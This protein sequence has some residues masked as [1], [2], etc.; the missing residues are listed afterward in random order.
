MSMKRERWE[1]VAQMH[2]AALE[3][4]EAAR[5]TFLQK[6][7]A[8]D[9][10]LRREVESLLA[11]EADAENF[12]DGS[13]LQAVAKKLAEEQRPHRAL[14]PG[15]KLGSYVIVGELG[16]GGMGEVYRARDSSLKREVAIKVLPA[17]Y[18]RDPDR[19]R[20]FELEAQAA[21]TLNH[22]NILSILHIG[23]QGGSPYIVSELLEGETLGDRLSQGPMRR[24]EAV[25]VAVAVA[26][27]LAAAH[28]KGITHRDLK[29]QNL[30]LGRDGRVKILDFG[31]AKLTQ[32]QA[33]SASGSMLT[34]GTET[35]PGI[36]LGTVGYMSPE[37]VRGQPADARSDIFAL[38]AVL[39]EM[40]TGTRAFHKPTSAETMYAILN[41]DPPNV[42]HISPNIPPALQRVMQRCLE[43]NPELRFQSS[44]DLAFAL[45]ALSDSGS[46][47]TSVI[48]Q[49]TTRR[50]LASAGLQLTTEN[51][52]AKNSYRTWIW[53]GAAACALA[54]LATFVLWWKLPPAVPR[55]IAIAQ[56]TDDGEAKCC[57]LATDGSRIY[58]NEGPFGGVKLAQA[59]VTGGQIG[60]IPTALGDPRVLA[61][62]PEG[63]GLL[64]SSGSSKDNN[65]SFPL[66]SIPL[67]VGEPH[68]F[69]NIEGNDGEFFPDGRIVFSRGTDVYAAGDDGSN[70]RKLFSAAGHVAEPH[71]AP[72]GKQIAFTL[73]GDDDVSVVVSKLDGST[74]RRIPASCCARWTP[75]GKYL[76]FS[77]VNVAR[78]DLWAVS[79][80][81]G[82]FRRSEQPVRLTN[83]PL[84]YGGS[85]VVLS[86]DGNRIFSIGKSLRG[87]LVRYDMRSKQFVPFLSGISASSPTFS[88]DGKWVAYLS[89]PD[90]TLWRS[91]VDGSE[92]LQLTTSN[93]G[94]PVFISPSGKRILFSGEG[95]TFEISMEGGSPPQKIAGENSE[96]AGWS[97]DG[98]FLLMTSR[99]S[100]KA[101]SEK[102]S[103]YLQ[104][105]DLQTGKLSIIPGSDGIDISQ[106]AGW[107][108]AQDLL[109]AAAP[110]RLVTFEFKTQK[111]SDLLLGDFLSCAPSVDLKYLYC[112][113]GGAEPKALRIRLADR[114]VETVASLKD[115][116]RTFFSLE[117]SVAPD[118]SPMFTRD[119]GSQE[120][121]ALTVEW[122]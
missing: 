84:S 95:G 107:W 113:T 29:P 16:A 92:R 99:V 58:F 111:W 57:R 89:Y 45:D 102:N 17:T 65:S 62:G 64:V 47:E 10:E 27:G 76:V 122:P 56:L 25:D 49:S 14:S 37:Q 80:K 23:E 66:W 71:V 118:G 54:A 75:D 79:A 40:L 42:S 114:K 61:L 121:Y 120:I 109:V 2:R 110:D 22:P 36:V 101:F 83:G 100:G 105:L 86:R 31:L 46:L 82:F 51:L 18:S 69:G 5:A 112:A 98:K 78:K 4:E 70:P 21:A 39:Y 96:P 88:K 93:V 38:G 117:I 13:A 77:N 15:V 50:V 87:E 26:R 33:A 43:K 104:T 48:G 81:S 73:F 8:G 30:F 72:G 12:M 59:A 44:S 108:I 3:V 53:I 9:E 52:R 28:E 1:Q 34:L 119:V 7:C 11:L 41:E 32:V 74:T 6:A 60:I 94:D 68:H 90:R 19:L 24:R 35:E 103:I 63:T 97:P 20:R 85:G 55:V 116:R 115:L 91:R 67:P 106:G